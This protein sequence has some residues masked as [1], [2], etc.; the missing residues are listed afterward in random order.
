MPTAVSAS[1][2][3]RRVT[4][5]TGWSSS[6]NSSRVG[7]V[8]PS[9]TPCLP[10]ATPE[11]L[12][13]SLAELAAMLANPSSRG[14][15]QGTVEAGPLPRVA[16][17]ALLVDQDQQRVAVAVQAHLAD[18]LPVPGGLAL[19]PVLA[20]AAGPVG[21]PPGGKGAVQRLVVHPGEHEH[22]S[23]VVLLDDGGDQPRRVAAQ[24]RGDPRVEGG[25]DGWN[26][27]HGVDCPRSAPRQGQQRAAAP[28]D[29]P[30]IGA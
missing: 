29:T 19:H 27:G 1:A 28:R 12:R 21:G 5:T 18:P 11:P 30:L 23:G 20:P 25:L 6:A 17:R 7:L 16:G 3:S 9:L 24:Q 22:L 2:S 8:T 10:R 14:H 26:G 4:G 15:L 13:S